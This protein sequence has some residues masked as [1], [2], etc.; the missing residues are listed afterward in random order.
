MFA[1][2]GLVVKT[3][4]GDNAAQAVHEREPGTDLEYQVDISFADAMRGAVKN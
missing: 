3:I 2:A 4:D 1:V